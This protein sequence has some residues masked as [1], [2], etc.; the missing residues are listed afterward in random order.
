VKIKW[1][2]KEETGV[3]F[4][5]LGYIIWDFGICIRHL[6]C[7]SE[8]GETDELWNIFVARMGKMRSATRFCY[9]NILEKVQ[10]EHREGNWKWH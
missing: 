6:L 4:R 1:T 10:L 5:L 2:W 7:D 8:V 9:K 3:A